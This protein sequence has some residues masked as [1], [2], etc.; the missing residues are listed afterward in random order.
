MGP[1]G[2]GCPG[3]G[4]DWAADGKNSTDLVAVWRIVLRPEGPVLSAQ[5][6]GLVEERSINDSSGLKGRFYQPRPKAWG[7]IDSRFFR[8]E[9]PVLSAQAEGLRERFFRPEGPV[10][11]AQAEGLGE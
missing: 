8:P 1:F 5:A 4:P 10:L 11:S 3:F 7:A 2:R 9:G 6:E